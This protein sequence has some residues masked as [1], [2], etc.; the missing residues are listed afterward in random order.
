MAFLREDD[1]FCIFLEFVEAGGDVPNLLLSPFRYSIF[2][3]N[4]DT[5]AEL[6]HCVYYGD[7]MKSLTKMMNS[8]SFVLQKL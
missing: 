2:F 7:E 4:M 5:E 3:H 8:I 1:V 6:V